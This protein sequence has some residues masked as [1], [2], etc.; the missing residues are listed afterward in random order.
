MCLS[1]SE[2]LRVHSRAKMLWRRLLKLGRIRHP[3]RLGLRS[4]TG[5]E[6]RLCKVHGS[7]VETRMLCAH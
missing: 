7:H 2:R 4:R 3:I 1:N 6:L 5:K